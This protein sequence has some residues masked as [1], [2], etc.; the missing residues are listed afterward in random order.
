VDL[1]TRPVGGVTVVKS[2][3]RRRE[4]AWKTAAFDL[5]VEAALIIDGDGLPMAANAAAEALFGS[6]LPLLM[7]KGLRGA[8]PPGEPLVRLIERSLAEG[9]CVRAPGLDIALFGRR[10]IVADATVTPLAGKV[11]LLTL[12][13]RDHRFASDKGA[14]GPSSAVGLSRLLAHEINNPLAGIR[15]AA[16]LL[17][18]GAAPRDVPLAQ[19]IVD[20]TDRIARL[21]DRLEALGEE[22]VLRP[23]AVNIHRVLDRVRGIIV[24]GGGEG[25]AVRENYDPSL[26]PVWG[27]E[28]KL[29]QL[30]LNLAKNAVEAARGRPDG[31]GEIGFSTA[32]RHGARICRPGRQATASAPLEVSIID[33]GPGVQDPLRDHL[34]EPF[35]TTKGCGPGLGLALAAKIVRAHGGSID[36]D[37]ELGRTIFRVRLPIA[38]AQG[39]EDAA[40]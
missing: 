32:F 17:K 31:G 8:F 18:A 16:Q 39:G 22:A 28:D 15:G 5:G 7:R 23:A 35:V 33:N 26:P 29:I 27:D 37:S 34:F 2:G 14:E 36:F 25:M 6:A 21:V 38:P 10:A 19:L 13:A 3:V 24:S 9:V 12:R 1:A 20:E 11:V 4:V 30:F 40:R